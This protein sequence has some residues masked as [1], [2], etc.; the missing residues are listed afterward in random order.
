[1]SYVMKTDLWWN[2]V[3][4]HE[5]AEIA[6]YK[7]YMVPSNKPMVREAD[8]SVKDASVFDLGKPAVDATNKCMVNLA[9]LPGMMT[10]DGNYN[11]GI[12]S[13][14]D[15]GNESSFLVI[16]DT[17]LDF[18]APDAPTDGGILRS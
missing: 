4:G 16:S 13:V 11:L 15:A 1:M 3:P 12:C 10:N 5:T 17:P 18:A 8:G 6:G 14:D 2:A 9:S 7:M